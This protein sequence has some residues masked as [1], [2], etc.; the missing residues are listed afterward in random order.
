MYRDEFTD[1][2]VIGIRKEILDLLKDRMKEH[3]E[4]ITP[5]FNMSAKF[6]TEN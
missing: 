1:A 6:D 2:V 3:V 4:R 5:Y